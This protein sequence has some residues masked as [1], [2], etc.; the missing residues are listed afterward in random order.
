MINPSTN[1]KIPLIPPLNLGSK[2]VADFKEKAGLFNELFSSKCTPVTSDNSLSRLVVL[3]SESSL[4]A[5]GFNNDDILKIIRSLNVNKAHGND[6]VS[7]IM[8]KIC[9]QAIV[10]PLSIF[11]KNR[12]DTGIFPDL[13]K[14]SNIVPVHKKA[15]KQLLQNYRPVPLLSI[16]GKIH[17]KIL[18]NSIFEHLQKNNLLCEN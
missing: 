10:E 12:I 11:Y 13:W 18:F 4:S 16:L 15:D 6:T 17:E 7:V 3:N 1:S 8:I 14:K 9:D 2:L 5:I